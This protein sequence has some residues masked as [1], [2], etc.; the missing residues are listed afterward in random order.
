M[1]TPERYDAIVIGAVQGGGPFASSTGPI[2]V[3]M[4]LVR[5][6]KRAMVK[7]F[8]AS[9]LRRIESTDGLELICSEG[10]RTG[11]RAVTVDGRVLQAELAFV[12]A[13]L[14]RLRRSWST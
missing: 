7:S 6:R 1:G 11:P 2:A 4:G 9:S 5:E 10:R 3:D 8:R 12:N 13:G 14:A